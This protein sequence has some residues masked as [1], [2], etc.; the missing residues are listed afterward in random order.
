MSINPALEAPLTDVPHT[1][2]GI[3]QSGRLYYFL[4]DTEPGPEE[5]VSAGVA[6]VE[7]ALERPVD[8]VY[9]PTAEVRWE[10]ITTVLESEPVRVQ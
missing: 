4:F 7:K 9:R 6:I 3:L 8:W 1:L 10:E 2:V 5:Y